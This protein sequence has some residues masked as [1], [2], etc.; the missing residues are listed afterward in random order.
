[1]QVNK[2]LKSKAFEI[3]LSCIEK[4]KSVCAD[5][6]KHKE[7]SI[8]DKRLLRTNQT[9]IK[10]DE[11]DI[12]NTHT[13]FN[14]HLITAAKYFIQCLIESEKYNLTIF[15]IVSLWLDNRTNDRLNK[16]M[17]EKLPSV[18][19]YKFL[20]I[21]PQITPHMALR[22]EADEFSNEINKLVGK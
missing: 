11:A 18:P 1:M 10:N 22:E 7:L 3:K 20:P 6:T 19:S 9:D 15:R 17:E 8:D 21:L 2:Y 4:A 12:E 14:N 13:S 16:L 5:L